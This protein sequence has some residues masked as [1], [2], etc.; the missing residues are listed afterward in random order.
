MTTDLAHAHLS[1]AERSATGP[2]SVL[3]DGLVRLIPRRLKIA[4]VLYSSAYLL[5][6]ASDEII[7]HLVVGAPWTF[8]EGHMVAL[9]AISVSL[10]VAA[11][12]D[13]SAL[14]LVGKQRLGLWYEVISSFG[15]AAGT[16]GHLR[17]HLDATFL[18][19][20]WVALWIAFYPLVVPATRRD[21]IIFSSLSALSSPL[22][23]LFWVRV[24]PGIEPRP[25]V[26][27]YVLAPNL[28]AAGLGIAAAAIVLG[29][30]RALDR[31]EKMGEY[32]LERLLGRGAMGEVWYATH[33][34]LARP[35][36]VKIVH[37]DL[38]ATSKEAGLLSIC[39][40]RCRTAL[41]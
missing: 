29:Y 9:V 18:G 19:I 7:L 20:S 21:A 28:I 11:L 31:A 27:L 38:L 32:H 5:S 13:S 33:Q 12:A 40:N 37:P 24:L 1:I 26:W 41:N 6:M 8:H 2:K 14:S 15:I 36:A 22:A 10:L 4:A 39:K 16:M 17:L 34:L 23:L 30:G 35:A 25:S 3:P